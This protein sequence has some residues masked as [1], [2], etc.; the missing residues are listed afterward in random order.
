MANYREG[1]LKK[2]L[3]GAA[4]RSLAAQSEKKNGFDFALVEES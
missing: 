1:R 3:E 4:N 2:C